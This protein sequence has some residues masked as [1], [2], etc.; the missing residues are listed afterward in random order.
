MKLIPLT[1]GLF[2]KVD[3][4]DYALLSRHKWHTHK[5]RDTFYARR[6][7]RSK[8]G[9]R[10]GYGMV[11]YMHREIMQILRDP[12]VEV[13][14]RDHNGLN[15]QRYN[16]RVCT[17]DQNLKN[18][19]IRKS[20]TSKIQG[21]CFD[22]KRKKWISQIMFHGK[23]INLGRF[24]DKQEAADAYKKAAEQYFGEFAHHLSTQSPSPPESSST[25][26]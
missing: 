8:N 19:K 5:S 17:H 10:G 9:I 18:L 24:I 23:T 3:D 14:H 2:A 6:R 15:C 20:N 13:D 7:D 16:L 22:K 21:V 12:S 1:K 25:D 11:I 4:S 26:R